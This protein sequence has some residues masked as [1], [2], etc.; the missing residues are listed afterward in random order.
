M[1]IPMSTKLSTGVLSLIVGLGFFFALP[2]VAFAYGPTPTSGTDGLFTFYYHAGQG[3]IITIPGD[4]VSIENDVSGTYCTGG[5]GYLYCDVSTSGLYGVWGVRDYPV[6]PGTYVDYTYTYNNPEPPFE[7]PYL[8]PVVDSLNSY[9]TGWDQVASL[10]MF[11]SE[12]VQC[13]SG[14]CA[15]ANSDFQGMEAIGTSVLGNE[16]GFSVYMKS[17]SGNVAVGLCKTGT[18]CADDWQYVVGSGSVSFPDSNWHKLTVYLREGSTHYEWCGLV[19]DVD[20][21]NCSWNTSNDTNS[22]NGTSYDGIQF[23]NYAPAA[24]TVY[25]D[26]ISSPSSGGGETET[27][28]AIISM[29]PEPD[30]LISTSTTEV[31][32]VTGFVQQSDFTDSTTVYI[33]WRQQTGVGVGDNSDL[34][35]WGE[36]EYLVTNFGNFTATT[37]LDNLDLHTGEYLAYAELRNPKFSILGYDMFWYSVVEPVMWRFTVSTSTEADKDSVIMLMNTTG[38]GI[39]NASTTAS[40]STS[41]SMCASLTNFNLVGCVKMLFTPDPDSV[42]QMKG[43][44]MSVLELFPW[45]YA[46]RAIALVSGVASSTD[47]GSTTIAGGVSSDLPS[48]NISLADTGLASAVGVEEINLTPWS[49]LMSEESILGTATSPKDGKTFREITEPYWNFLVVF[50][51]GF[52]MVLQLLGI[53]VV[54]GA[55]Q[56]IINSRKQAR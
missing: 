16:L 13:F 33:R 31:I 1:N 36:Y 28:T 24:G 5:G 51:F 45:G 20:I 55:E 38:I 23:V 4:E 17:T 22:V 44:A 25:V 9:P 14:N 52:S 50:M 27:V 26:E 48:L 8:S 7:G 18:S 29:I 43:Q 40:I 11:G 2:A 19:D 35:E 21:N 47:I 12:T 41:T 6:Y 54:G 53:N 10:T 3:A 32:G 56:A 42:E 37:S 15:V 34:E 30:S 39:V 49:M 46:T